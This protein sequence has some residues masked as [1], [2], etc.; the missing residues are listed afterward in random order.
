MTMN[1]IRIPFHGPG[2]EPRDALI[3][4]V[5]SCIAWDAREGPRARPR[6]CGG[7]GDTHASSGGG[8]VERLVG[9]GR[10]RSARVP[11]RSQ[12]HYLSLTLSTFISFFPLS[13]HQHTLLSRL[14]ISLSDS[15]SE[16][17]SPRNKHEQQHA[18]RTTHFRGG[19]SE[20][21]SAEE[22]SDAEPRVGLLRRRRKK[23]TTT[24]EEEEREEEEEG[25]GGGGGKKK[26]K[27]K[28]EDKIR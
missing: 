6:P 27:K 4:S 15:S 10:R 21:S 5:A 7:L 12:V 9:R 2:H 26:K 14:S 18:T 13:F 19:G 20:H 17:V 8:R 16:Q 3:A 25:G 22:R 28:R 24:R 23:S 11:P 1:G